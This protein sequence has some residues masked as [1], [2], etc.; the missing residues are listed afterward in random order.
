ME[1][2][3]T[4]AILT[5]QPAIGDSDAKEVSPFILPKDYM[6]Y[7]NQIHEKINDFINLNIWRG[8]EKM[9]L[10]QWLKNFTTDEE[11]YFAACI[12]DNLIY[13]SDSQ[14][15][16][17]LFNLISID[18]PNLIL[19]H[20]P[21]GVNPL[22]TLGGFKNSVDPSIR[23]VCVKGEFDAPSK[24]SHF[25]ARML[26]RKMM[27]NENWIITPDKIDSCLKSGT[28]CFVFIDDFLGTGDQFH[29]MAED[30]KLKEKLELVDTFFAYAPLTAHSDGVTFLNQSY[31]KLKITFVEKLDETN[32]V[33]NSAFNDGVNSPEGSRKFYIDFMKRKSGLGDLI[34]DSALGHGRLE[35]TYV[36][37]QSVPDNNISLIYWNLNSSINALF[38]R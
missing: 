15:E 26:K 27:I 21:A 32:S 35:L 38:Y 9:K 22:V 4:Q 20:K 29:E 8:I 3:D 30:I 14:T 10:K 16:S 18:I 25:V 17:M 13:R 28:K 7:V 12:L 6:V 33:F 36:F 31:P 11:K 5:V 19:N 24:S 2:S 1:Q 23:L 34:K 37:E